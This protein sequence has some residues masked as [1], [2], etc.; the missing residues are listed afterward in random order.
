MAGML[1]TPVAVRGI[2][3]VGAESNDVFE[4]QGVPAVVCSDESLL[5]ALNFAVEHRDMR[6]ADARLCFDAPCD[7]LEDRIRAAGACTQAY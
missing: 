6:D 4:D 1:W 2:A 3:R 7:G 5:E